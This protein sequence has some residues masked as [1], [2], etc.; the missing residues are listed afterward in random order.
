MDFKYYMDIPTTT[1]VWFKLLDKNGKLVEDFPNH[2]CYSG[3][4]HGFSKKARRIQVY[5]EKAKVPYNT[6]C[7]R[8]WITDLNEMGF[9][10]TF[11]EDLLP[12]AATKAEG[13]ANAT[14]NEG[15]TDMA[16][17]LMRHGNEPP[18]SPNMFHNFYVNLDDYE[19]KNHLFSTLSLIRCL[20]ESGINRV[21]EVY[22]GIMDADPGMDK[23]EACQA[24]HKKVSNRKN[25]YDPKSYANTGHMVTFD[26]NGENVSREE[27]MNRFKKAKVDLRDSGYLEINPAWNAAGEGR[28]GNKVF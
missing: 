8:R 11:S 12:D 3:I 26:G 17:L 19:D 22:F 2:P 20:T 27:L 25:I 9:P 1:Y 13:F 14:V 16:L 4:I 6:A 21:P 5:H 23:L 10:C 28:Y 15:L 18:A 24:A 7:I